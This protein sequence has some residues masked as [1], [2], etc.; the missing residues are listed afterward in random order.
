MTKNILHEISSLDGQLKIY[1]EPDLKYTISNF[2]RPLIE[3][4]RVNKK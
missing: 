3:T 4:L 2:V 1:F